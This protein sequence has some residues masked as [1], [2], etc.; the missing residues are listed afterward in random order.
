MRKKSTTSTV[1]GLLIFLSIS[2]SAEENFSSSFCIK[3]GIQ[4][5]AQKMGEKLIQCEVC[6]RTLGVEGEPLSGIPV[7]LICRAET[8]EGIS[9]RNFLQGNTNEKGV[10][11][12]FLVLDGSETKS[13]VF[14]EAHS[15]LIKGE[16]AVFPLRLVNIEGR[17]FLI[18]LDQGAPAYL[19][20]P[21]SSL[22]YKYRIAQL[23]KSL[24]RFPREWKSSAQMLKAI[25][26]FTG[27]YLEL[28][29]EELENLLN[30]VIAAAP[31]KFHLIKRELVEALINVESK[32]NPLALGKRGELGL[33]QL[34]P[35]IAKEEAFGGLR[36]ENTLGA[37]RNLY[38]RKI[39]PEQ[40]FDLLLSD[41][42]SD[43]WRNLWTTLSFLE[44]LYQKFEGNELKAILAYNC[45][46]SRV[47]RAT[48]RNGEIN[49]LRIP[50]TTRWE[51][52]PQ[53]LKSMGR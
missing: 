39:T 21:G 3:I 25:N 7:K 36:T 29:G 40:F 31:Q 48:H 18:P 26:E 4:E 45:G 51:Y 44:Y 32:R 14:L 41:E 52:L 23:K 5:E 6:V 9:F 46:G 28:T 20:S 53:I 2:I 50:S 24:T 33:G 47:V 27:K 11:S 13:E 34:L 42:R 16:K 37:I 49:L 43:P 15:D 19:I 17:T 38:R 1:A 8:K 22:P 30:E 35:W 10:I 12:G